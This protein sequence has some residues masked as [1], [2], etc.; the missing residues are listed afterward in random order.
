MD[1]D[2]INHAAIANRE[3]HARLLQPTLQNGLRTDFYQSLW[4]GIDVHEINLDTLHHLPL[5][6]KQAIREAGSSAQFKDGLICNEIFTSGTTGVPLVTLRGHREQE[7]IQRF[8]LEV[9]SQEHHG[10]LLRGLQLNNPYHGSHNTIPS[11]FHVH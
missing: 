4:K 9:H 2:V 7:Y 10:K 8:F 6:E 3:F 5:V 11:P 1:I